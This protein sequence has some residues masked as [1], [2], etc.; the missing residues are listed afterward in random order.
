MIMIIKPKVEGQKIKE[1]TAGGLYQNER[2]AV[3]KDNVL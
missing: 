3:N 1:Y 2:L